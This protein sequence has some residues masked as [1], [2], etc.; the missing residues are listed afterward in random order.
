MKKPSTEINDSTVF[1]LDTVSC[2]IPILPTEIHC[3]SDK[4]I[5][6][7]D[8]SESIQEQVV[9]VEKQLRREIEECKLDIEKLKNETEKTTEGVKEEEC[10]LTEVKLKYKG[11]LQSALL[12]QKITLKEKYLG[13][14]ELLQSSIDKNSDREDKLLKGIIKHQPKTIAKEFSDQENLFKQQSTK[15]HNEYER[16]LKSLVT[17]NK[18][19]TAQKEE[20]EHRLSNIELHKQ[21]HSIRHCSKQKSL[22]TKVPL[23]AKCKA[24]RSLQRELTNKVLRIQSYLFN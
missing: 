13:K 5:Q 6:T 2:G 14:C 9:S 19:I 12:K 22:T 7:N 3:L 18:E 17:T 21:I 8:H 10:K 15:L 16:K 4:N 23:C 20:L 11:K 1:V 24:F